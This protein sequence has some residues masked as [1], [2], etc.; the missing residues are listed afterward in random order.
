MGFSDAGAGAGFACGGRADFKRIDPDRLG[1]IL[2]LGRAK[3]ADR[4]IEPTLDLTIGVLGHADCAGLGDAL[5]ARG[6][7]NAV[8]HQIA[9]ALLDHVAQVNADAELNSAVRRHARISFDE[10]MLHFDRATHRVDHAAKFGEDPRR[11]CA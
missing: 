10:T 1:D 2:E 6:D 3:I 11:R 7:I 9:V 4:E 5:Q 8:A